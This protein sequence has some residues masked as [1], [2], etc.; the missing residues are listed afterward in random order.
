LAEASRKM[1]NA[2]QRQRHE[3]QNETGRQRGEIEKADDLRDRAKRAYQQEIAQRDHAVAK[4]AKI[5]IGQDHHAASQRKKQEEE[6]E[7]IEVFDGRHKTGEKNRGR[8]HRAPPIEP[9][10]HQR[11][12]DQRDGK[13]NERDAGAFAVEQP[14]RQRH[15]AERECKF[16]PDGDDAGRDRGREAG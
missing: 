4:P 8:L 2:A 13:E 11:S 14:I 5:G 9:I 10:G 16:R 3:P 12:A 1:K 6:R 15:K 7:R